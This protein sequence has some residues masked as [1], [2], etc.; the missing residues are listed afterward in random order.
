MESTKKGYTGPGMHRTIREHNGKSYGVIGLIKAITVSSN[1]YFA[2]LGLER[3][4]HEKI[5][6]MAQDYGFNQIIPWNSRNPLWAVAK[7]K[8]PLDNIEL[9]PDELASSSF[10]QYGVSATP[11]QM[12]MVAVIVENGGYGGT[13][14]APIAK[15]ILAAAQKRGYLQ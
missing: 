7:S 6:S 9:T 14:A 12:C 10:G 1:Q 4:G 15:K 2:A 13:V 11:L 8:Y 5:F 3:L